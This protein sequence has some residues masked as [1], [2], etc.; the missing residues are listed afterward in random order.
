MGRVGDWECIV[1]GFGKQY[2][3]QTVGDGYEYADIEWS[4]LN[5]GNGCSIK[6]CT[7][8][9]VGVSGRFRGL[10]GG[11]TNSVIAGK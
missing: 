11:F 5:E 10:W 2:I 1:L 8:Y 7:I 9:N 3:R 6:K 4:P